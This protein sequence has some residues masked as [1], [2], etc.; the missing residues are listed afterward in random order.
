MW[1]IKFFDTPQEMHHWLS[2]MMED[3]EYQEL[4]VNN[5]YAVEWRPVKRILFDDQE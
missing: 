4:F 1:Q 5:G 3:I 2:E